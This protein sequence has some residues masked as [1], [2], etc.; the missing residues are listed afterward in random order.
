MPKRR[1][2]DS[3]VDAE[4]D[5]RFEPTELPGFAMDMFHDALD[6]AFNDFGGLRQDQKAVAAA[7]GTL[8]WL[9]GEHPNF[10][11]GHHHLALILDETGR[12][13]EARF[14]WER[15]VNIGMQGF[16]E[17]FCTPGNKIKWGG[18]GDR[19]FLRSY[20][21]VGLQCMKEGN[22]FRAIAIFSTM[23]K[24]SPNDN[25]GV[26]SLLVECFLEIDR[27]GDVLRICMM[28]PD[29]RMEHILY[30][31]VLALFK[32][33][34]KEKAEKALSQAVISLPKVA[35]ELVKRSH[36]PPLKMWKDSITM[37]GDDQAYYY[38]ERQGKVWKK[39]PGAMDFI[40]GFLKTK[41]VAR[42]D[43]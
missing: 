1:Q 15:A 32:I 22:Y 36:K 3:E 14:H 33:G 41:P 27:P 37:G 43:I 39:T 8:R 17:D 6:I 24:I 2:S 28:F 40:K 30:G 34:K 7:E 35:A 4:K 9:L 42:G 31:K 26:R 38:W 20:H 19:S 25:Q 21:C 12:T 18:L 23:L 11:D 29:D 5:L 10:I 16:I 13:D